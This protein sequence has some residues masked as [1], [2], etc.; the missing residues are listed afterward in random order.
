[1][2][3]HSIGVDTIEMPALR[4]PCAEGVPTTSSAQVQVDLAALSHRGYVR[5]TNE[6][7][8]LILRF[9]RSLET[10][11]TS[12]PADALPARSEEVGYGLFVADGM[13]GCV[14]GEVAS[15][16]AITTLVNLVLQTPDWIL[17]SDPQNIEQVID[18]MSERFRRIHD[19]LRDEGRDDPS[20]KGMGTTMTLV[21][22]LGP[23]LVIGHVGDSRA[24]L[25][26]GDE[27]FQ[28]TRDHTVLQ[29]LLDTGALTAEEAARHPGRHV[30]T[31]SLGACADGCDGD[32]HSVVLA[33]GDDL[34]LCSDGLTNM[35]DDTHIMPVLRDAASA[36]DACQALVSLALENGG[37]DNVTVALARYHFPRSEGAV[38]C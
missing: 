15:R 13:G 35:V 5:T 9:G 29:T 11:R 20:L 24:Y 32:F 27:L 6:D 17:S 25:R 4:G 22:S 3:A 31:R 21:C 12:L 36:D 10:L 7:H 34:L 18:R 2:N 14:G 23:R 16:T 33:D 30:L 19:A 28:L 26:R 8:F 1:M 38:D 37:K